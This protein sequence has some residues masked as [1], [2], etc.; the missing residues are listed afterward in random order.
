MLFILAIRIYE[1]TRSNAAVSALYIAFGVPAVV[2]G[3]VAGVIVDHLDKRRVLAWCSIGRA[4]LMIVLF[5]FPSTLLALYFVMFMNSV[6]SQFHVP[7]E[8]PMI[9]RLVPQRALLSA[10]SLFSFTFFTSIAIGFILAGP[11]LQYAGAYGSFFLLI[12]L[13]IIA[14]SSVSQIPVQK[15]HTTGIKRALTYSA[16]FLFKRIA[17]D[18]RSGLAF[19]R[20]S[21]P[22]RNAL[23][24]LSGTQVVLAILGSLGPG[25][26]DR[27]LHIPV[28]NASIVILGPAVL[29]I[30]FGALWVGNFGSKYTNSFL[31]HTGLLFG[32]AI[33]MLI[34]LFIQFRMRGPLVI[35]MTLVLFFLLCV[36]NSFLDVPSNATLQQEAT[37]DMRGKIYGILTAT[38]GGI[39]ILPV[40][41]GGI[42]ADAFG[43]G[44]V[45]FVVGA[46][47]LLYGVAEIKNLI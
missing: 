3:V 4:V 7:A 22:I 35:P 9:P 28:T 45:L 47:I 37:G 12:T 33:M 26:A 10:N 23:I 38:G 17:T 34:A 11:V 32:G 6:L 42:L 31:T 2:F 15:E 40:V 20:H 5:F 41:L 16:P 27:F 18:M 13:Y 19:V 1:N 39:G 25:I 8:A 36:A 46:V 21:R 43:I 24:L 14:S 30:I 44:K 29:G